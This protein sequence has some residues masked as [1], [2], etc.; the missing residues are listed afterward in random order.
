MIKLTMDMPLI[1][2][3]LSIDM[4]NSFRDHLQR[5]YDKLLQRPYD[6]QIQ[7]PMDLLMWADNNLPSIKVSFVGKDEIAEEEEKLQPRS[8]DALT[9]TGTQGLH[10]FVPVP[11]SRCSPH[12]DRHTTTT[13]VRP[14]PWL[15]VQPSQ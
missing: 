13:L 6:K 4:C 1:I 11:G 3:A 7:T 9:V 8:A 15:K 10:S 5:P 14:C 2:T 12:S